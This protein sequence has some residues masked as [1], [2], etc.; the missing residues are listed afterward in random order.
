V[1]DDSPSINGGQPDEQAVLQHYG[2]AGGFEEP[3]TEGYG[4]SLPDDPAYGDRSTAVSERERVELREGH[5]DTDDVAPVR[6]RSSPN[7][8]QPA[9]TPPTDDG[10]R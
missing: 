2:L 4:D 9:E 7:A 8:L 1:I 3:D 6:G 10:V 5:G